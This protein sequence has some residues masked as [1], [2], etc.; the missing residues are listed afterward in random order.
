M[1]RTLEGEI[2]RLGENISSLEEK[3]YA[4]KVATDCIKLWCTQTP[5]LSSSDGKIEASFNWSGYSR[6][7]FSGND[8]E[9]YEK[10]PQLSVGN[11]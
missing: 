1:M 4:A 7:E 11:S 6:D 9:I 3:R 5:Y 2:S 10:V 8:K